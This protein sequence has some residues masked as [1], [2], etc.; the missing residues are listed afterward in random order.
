MMS[1]EDFAALEPCLEPMTLT[2]RQ[3]LVR[4]NVPIEYTY[5]PD[6]GQISVTVSATGRT[7]I[8]VALIGRESVSGLVL[9]AGVD[10]TPLRSFVQV[11]GSGWRIRAKVLTDAMLTSPSLM[12]QSIMFHHCFTNQI[13]FTALA[14]GSLSVPKRLARWLLMSH[15]R[16][17]GDEL[18]FVHEFLAV[19]L[20]VR[21]AGITEA[22]HILEGNGAIR[23]TRG[24]ITVRDRS[25]L[26]ELASGTY[27][28]PEAEYQRLLGPLV[29]AA[30]LR[31]APLGEGV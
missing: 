2:L 30:A 13:S 29:A 4:P 20:A 17:E 28:P 24:R 19:M 8:E 22:I 5:F 7:E 12:Q 25:K 16:A 1:D 21:R 23:A 9:G 14:H 15:D 11:P 31:T 10:R 18:P 3:E 26:I 27:G 6:D